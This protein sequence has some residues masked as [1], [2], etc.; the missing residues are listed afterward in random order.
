VAERFGGDVLEDEELA[1]W[2]RGRREDGRGDCPGRGGAR[3]N[4]RQGPTP[5]AIDADP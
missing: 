1:H 3:N 4:A 5:A 2:V